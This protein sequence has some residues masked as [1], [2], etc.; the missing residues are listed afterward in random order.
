MATSPRHARQR[1]V[2]GT[3]MCYGG[4]WSSRRFAFLQRPHTT[5]RMSQPPNREQPLYAWIITINREPTD[6]ERKH[7][8]PSWRQEFAIRLGCPDV[9]SFPSGNSQFAGC[10]SVA[11]R[12]SESYIRD[13]RSIDCTLRETQRPTYRIRRCAKRV[14]RR[15]SICCGKT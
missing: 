14:V 11:E 15:T 2:H 10:K 6:A 8:Q 4:V 1:L 13:T 5:R 9:Q 3:S 7:L 12:P